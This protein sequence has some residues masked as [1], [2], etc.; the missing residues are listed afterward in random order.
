MT[1]EQNLS[2]GDLVYSQINSDLIDNISE[3]LKYL[4]W[5]KL[6]I[7]LLIIKF[8]IKNH[9]E[10]Y[11]L[12]KITDEILIDL[13][14]DEKNKNL[15]DSENNN[16]KNKK[17]KK[18]K[19]ENSILCGNDYGAWIYSFGFYKIHQMRKIQHG[20]TSINNY[21]ENG[22]EC[23]PNNSTNFKY[24]DVKEVEVYKIIL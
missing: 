14:R 5:R 6:G 24:F 15:N 3:N 17:Y 20:G 16:D 4:D 1:T 22:A 19:K 23:L 13:L 10:K 2:F 8:L 9:N 11:S 21:Y 12:N 18:I 7:D